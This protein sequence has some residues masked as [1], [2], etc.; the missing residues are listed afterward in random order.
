MSNNSPE[1]TSLPP[2]SPAHSEVSEGTSGFRKLWQEPD[3]ESNNSG[4]SD[5]WE[6]EEITQQFVRSRAGSR[7][8]VQQPSCLATCGLACAQSCERFLIHPDSRFG[9]FWNVIVA[10]LLIYTATIFPYVLCFYEFRINGAIVM[11]TGWQVLDIIVDWLFRTDLVLCFITAYYDGVTGELVKDPRRIAADY[12]R[13]FFIIDLIACLP[14][15]AFVLLLAQ[16]GG[17]H[18]EGENGRDSHKATRLLRLNRV[19]KLARL[20]RLTRLAR[21]LRLFKVNKAL[22]KSVLM[23]KFFQTRG[24]RIAKFG[25]F[26]FISV[27]ILACGWY[28]TA[29]LHDVD[30]DETWIVRRNVADKEPRSQWVQAMYFV[31]A[32]FTTVG[33]GDI[34]AVTDAEVVYAV[35]TM[36]VGALVHSFIIS[37]MLNIITFVDDAALEMRARAEAVLSFCNHAEVGRLG[38]KELQHYV[39]YH[40][41]PT[42]KYDRSMM[43]HLLVTFFPRPVTEK[44]ME[45]VYGGHLLRNA[46]WNAASIPSG[47]ASVSVQPAAGD[48]QLPLLAAVHVVRR[49]LTREQVAFYHGDHP[50]ALWL[51]QSGTI[52]AV[53]MP[54]KIGGVSF[55]ETATTLGSLF[56]HKKSSGSTFDGLARGAASKA[57]AA[58]QA[59]LRTAHA[60]GAAVEK[61]AVGVASSASAASKAATTAAAAAVGVAARSTSFRAPTA[62]MLRGARGQKHPAVIDTTISESAPEDDRREEQLN[63]SMD[64]AVDEEGQSHGN[65]SRSPR[66]AALKN[67]RSAED[68]GDVAEDSS[69]ADGEAYLD[70]IMDAAG[71][72]PGL[73]SATSADCLVS[74]KSPPSAGS[75]PPKLQKNP[76][77]GTVWPYQLV[78]SGG[79]FGEM[80]LLFPHPRKASYRAESKNL[81]ALLLPRQAFNLMMGQHP[82][83]FELLKRAARRR[84]AYR[85]RLLKRLKKPG[86]SYRSLAARCIQRC[87]RRA[88]LHLQKQGA[89]HGSQ[90]QTPVG[91]APRPAGADKDQTIQTLSGTDGADGIVQEE[92]V[93]PEAGQ[94]VPPVNV[95]HGHGTAAVHLLVK[96]DPPSEHCSHSLTQSRSTSSKIA[97]SGGGCFPGVCGPPLA[98]SSTSSAEVVLEGLS[99]PVFASPTNLENAENE[100]NESSTA[101]NPVNADSALV[102]SSGAGPGLSMDDYAVFRSNGYSGGSDDVG[103]GSRCIMGSPGTR[104]LHY[105]ILLPLV[106]F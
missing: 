32:V 26:L 101:G 81:I 41:E 54:S 31:L 58:R 7:G 79:F 4:S 36:L 72:S 29:V 66:T 21:L 69:S 30:S 91:S 35:F 76:R 67:G 77:E 60:A 97:A 83:S 85:E 38:T 50:H 80:E 27:H 78:S 11:S 5:V 62:A 2:K 8:Y 37:E 63:V 22:K 84:E 48:W 105:H 13:G 95:D 106:F 103:G 98:T 43:Q 45:S 28:L 61:A 55:H 44:L 18:V 49:N 71:G 73:D 104:A 6:Q 3:A 34:K 12:L 39:D 51:V 70:A 53:A 88:L 92:L 93:T 89:P 40:K 86:I 56:T 59:A 82:K 90:G 75:A 10:I 64:S 24:A 17:S 74:A 52:A 99:R 102:K 96:Q 19:G 23:R 16:D 15:E 65:N 57:E 20:A 9:K 42:V 87:W 46:F 94:A 47:F 14:G 25:S 100:C 68:T 33:F 1:K